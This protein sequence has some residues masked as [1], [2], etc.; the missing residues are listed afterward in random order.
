MSIHK[1]LKVA[2][3]LVRKRSVMTRGERLE[4]L[5]ELGK[6]DESKSVFNLP[7]TRMPVAKKLGKKKKKKKDDEAADAKK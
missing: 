7:K 2:A 3:S 6:W 4:R 5:E 1:S